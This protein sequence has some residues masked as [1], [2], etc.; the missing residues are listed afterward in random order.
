VCSCWMCG[1]PRRLRNSNGPSL[2]AQE[3]RSIA[4]FRSQ[5]EEVGHG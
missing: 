5:L 4:D 3:L 2:R 1:N